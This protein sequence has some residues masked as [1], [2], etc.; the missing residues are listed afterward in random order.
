M[1]AK[2]YEE[3][4]KVAEEINEVNKEYGYYAMLAMILNVARKEPIIALGIRNIG[5]AEY[6]QLARA[7]I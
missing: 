6:F 2:L 5:I 3:I 1:N 7:G 4:K